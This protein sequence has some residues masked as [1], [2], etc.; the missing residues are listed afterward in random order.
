MTTPTLEGIQ[1]ARQHLV[2]INHEPARATLKAAL[3]LVEADLRRPIV[4]RMA[5][6]GAWIVGVGDRLTQVPGT[7]RGLLPAWAACAHGRAS[8][9]E[10]YVYDEKAPAD[11]IR[12]SIKGACAALVKRACPELAQVF[13]SMIKVE[14]SADRI[15]YTGKRA[16]DTGTF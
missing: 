10:F 12:T 15:V 2:F 16:I 14:G 4:F 9:A 3:D 8:L 1:Q 11:A 6:G 13:E 5:P 7:E